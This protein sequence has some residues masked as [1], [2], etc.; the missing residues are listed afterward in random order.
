MVP[1]PDRLDHRVGEPQVEELV[2]AHLAEEVVDPI[3][4]G[5]VDVL[6]YFRGE[7]ACG[8][9]IVAKRLLD[10]HA[11]RLGQAGRR[12]LLDHRAEQ[13]RR[14]LEVEDRAL[15]SLHVPAQPL[16][17][18]WVGE[19]A[20]DVGESRCEPVKDVSV[21][22]LARFFDAL[23]SVLAQVLDRP[24]VARDT[25]NRTIQQ[26]AQLEPIQR[27]EGHHLRE[28]AR[29]AEDH[30]RVRGG[31]RA[32]AVPTPHGVLARRCRCAHAQLVLSSETGGQ[33]SLEAAEQGL[34]ARARGRASYDSGEV[35]P[36]HSA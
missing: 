13:K 25:D 30:Q 11:G 19:V 6:V 15:G 20:A 5:L 21:E 1:V 26:A 3:Q 31:G 18:R 22:C 8:L 27:P 2:D 14:D 35:T 17:G 28:I 34:S 24:V 29:D 23:G 7:R 12:Q 9:E 4:L 16:V 36:R 33:G 32:G 10:D